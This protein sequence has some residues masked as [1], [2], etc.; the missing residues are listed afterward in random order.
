MQVSKETF[1]TLFKSEY[2]DAVYRKFSDE[3][4]NLLIDYIEKQEAS[5]TDKLNYTPKDLYESY[6][7]E[8]LKEAIEF[9]D[10]DV[11]LN[12]NHTEAEQQKTM[13]AAIEAY[14]EMFDAFVG[15]T[16]TNRVVYCSDKAS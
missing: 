5:E 12:N 11:E 7:E 3:G 2:P 1:L 14:F 6:W 13:K 15:F 10:I 16:S 9:Y 4:L 8:P